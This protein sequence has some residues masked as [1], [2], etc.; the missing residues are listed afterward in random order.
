MSDLKLPPAGSWGQASALEP[1]G[2]WALR[3]SP[4]DAQRLTPWGVPLPDRMLSASE[5]DGH[6]A[7]R[8]GPDEWLL[9][10][11]AGSLPTLATLGGGAPPHALID[12]SDRHLG[13]EL[14]GPGVRDLLAAGCPLDLDARA[15][16]VGFATRTLLGK[17]E[18][19]LWRREDAGTGA[20]RFRLEA[21]RSFWPYV[22][23]LLTEAAAA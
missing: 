5:V 1:T 13:A 15:M 14:E 10:G 9:F 19:L 21:W 7:L 23:A 2:R 18:V 16:P 17:A 6:A 20:A 4:E 22:V 8:L 11:P 3:A 12:L